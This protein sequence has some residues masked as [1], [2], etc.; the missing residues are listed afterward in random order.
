[1][2]S[3][4]KRYTDL[5]RRFDSQHLH[6][7]AEAVD[8]VKSL[9]TA[10]WKPDINP[11]DNPDLYDADNPKLV[12]ENHNPVHPES[13]AGIKARQALASQPGK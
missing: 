1:M 9:G 7:P 5:G 11:T 10:G 13:K 8:L 4:G 6:T 12:D 2:A 3:R